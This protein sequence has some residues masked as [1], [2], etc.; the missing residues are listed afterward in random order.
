MVYIIYRDKFSW[1]SAAG[2]KAA[3]NRSGDIA[4]ANKQKIFILG[5]I[6]YL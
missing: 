3:S 2:N 1:Y 5:H 4:A 6:M